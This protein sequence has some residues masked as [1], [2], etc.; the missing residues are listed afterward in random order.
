[1]L[2]IHRISSRVPIGRRLGI[3]NFKNHSLFLKKNF[4]NFNSDSSVS[5]DDVTALR[6]LRLD[7]NKKVGGIVRSSDDEILTLKELRSA[8]FIAAKQCHPDVAKFRKE[9]ARKNK[10]TIEIDASSNFLRVT[11]AYE[12]LSAMIGSSQRPTK[13]L[14]SEKEEAQFRRNCDE[15]L[16]IPADVV[17]ESK[18][19]P[20][21]RQWLQ[22][23]SD[24]AFHW[25]LFLMMVSNS[26]VFLPLGNLGVNFRVVV[27]I[28]YN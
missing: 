22:G 24:G 12:Y 9:S 17:E 16:G 4:R 19:C 15:W 1:M 18:R 27:C 11:E 3:F 7:E 25:N 14:V 2:S 20:L 21:F 26:S 8:Y 6:L 13:D 10:K 5:L 23:R 28:D